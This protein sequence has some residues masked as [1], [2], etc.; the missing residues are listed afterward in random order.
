MKYNNMLEARFLARPNRFIAYIEVDGK[1]EVCHVKNT[2]RCKELLISGCTI[3]VQHHDN[4]KRKTKYSL[5]A[6]KKGELLI[7]M[8]S[9]APNKVVQ[10]WLKEKQ[11]FGHM[12][13]LKPEYTHGDSCFDFY[14]ETEAKKMFVE[15]KG[16]TLEEDGVVK[17]PDAPTERGVKHVRELAELAQ[18]GYECAIIFVVQMSGMKYFT[19]N[20]QTHAEF[21]E[22]LGNAKNAGVQIYAYECDVEVDSL[23]ITK[24]IPVKL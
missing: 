8:D 21:G 24:E 19:P 1:E 17:F 7:N 13:L 9:Q 11:P 6:V 16:V 10:E 12:T 5:I 15:I 20:W 14:L 23:N 22:A 18:E 2:G 4:E 3:Y